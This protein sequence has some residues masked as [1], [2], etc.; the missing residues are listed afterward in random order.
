MFVTEQ[1]VKTITNKSVSLD[2]ITRAQYV[3]ETFIG[4]FE[5]DVENTNDLELLKRATAYQSAYMVDS[6]DIVFEQLKA[7]TII[8]NDSSTTFK[9]SDEFSPWIAPL[10]VMACKKL[11]FY[12]SRTIKTGKISPVSGLDYSADWVTL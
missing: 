3:I 8:Q 7:S 12:R 5:D 9:Q 2:L 1:Q 10:A 6:E 4:K 11:S